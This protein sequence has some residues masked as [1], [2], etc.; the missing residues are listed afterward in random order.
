MDDPDVALRVLMMRGAMS[1]VSRGCRIMVA[2]RRFQQVVHPRRYLRWGAEA[3]CLAGL[4]WGFRS[5]ARVEGHRV[6]SR[7]PNQRSPAPKPTSDTYRSGGF[8]RRRL[9]SLIQMLRHERADR[10]RLHR[11]ASAATSR[12]QTK[13]GSPPT[14]ART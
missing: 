9:V 13:R 6:R 14:A 8:H 10:S 2:E 12:L 5:T 4:A 7:L 11:L 3:V 1:A